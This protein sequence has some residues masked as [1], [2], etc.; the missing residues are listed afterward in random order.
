MAK[1]TQTAGE[2]KWERPAHSG[3]EA[4]AYGEVVPVG[5]VRKY[6]DGSTY[7]ITENGAKRISQFMDNYNW[8]KPAHSAFEAP[9]IGE[10]D[11]RSAGTVFR[12]GYGNTCVITESGFSKVIKKA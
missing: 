1:R 3:F 7:V 4:P 9:A 12:D 6:Q 8:V 2:E 11:T 5:T 10:V